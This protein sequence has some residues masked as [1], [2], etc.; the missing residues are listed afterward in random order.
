MRNRS[1]VKS[2]NKAILARI[3][4][5]CAS[6]LNFGKRRTRENSNKLIP[7]KKPL[8]SLRQSVRPRLHKWLIGSLLKKNSV[9]RGNCKIRIG[10]K[11]GG[12]LKSGINEVSST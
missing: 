8:S 11:Q 6:L 4:R 7:R 3:N 2:E 5:L 1:I 10:K 12:G 9:W